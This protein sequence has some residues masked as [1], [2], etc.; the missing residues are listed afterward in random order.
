MDN[1]ARKSRDSGE[2]SF[3]ARA[4]NR[5]SLI[6]IGFVLDRPPCDALRLLRGDLVCPNLVRALSLARP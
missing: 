5:S 2:I 1:M 6:S 3:G 4:C